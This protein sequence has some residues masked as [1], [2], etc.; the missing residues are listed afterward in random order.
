MSGASTTDV[1]L[2]NLRLF[3]EIS[4]SGHTYITNYVDFN[5]NVY[6]CQLAVISPF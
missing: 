5:V 6:S 3:A 4:S 1:A 2:Y